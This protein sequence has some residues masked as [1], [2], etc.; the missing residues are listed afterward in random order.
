MGRTES[1]RRD[2]RPYWEAV[3][4]ICYCLIDVVR[5]ERIMQDMRADVTNLCGNLGSDLTLDVQIPVHRVTAVR[6]WIKITCSR[7]R[8]IDKGQNVRE[9]TRREPL[10]AERK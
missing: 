7:S 5:G 4:E 2:R 9:G 3:N 8:G 6:M 10:L 1:L